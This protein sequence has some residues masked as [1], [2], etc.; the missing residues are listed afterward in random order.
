MSA[1]LVKT[2]TPGVYRRGSRYVVCFRDQYG[3]PRKRSAA[4]LAEARELKAA[5]VTDV[6]RGEY[7]P[8]ARLRF[9]AYARECGASYRGRTSRGIRPETLLD[10][11]ADLERHIIPLLGQLE[12][13]AIEP[14]DLKRVAASLADKGL[15]PA[16]IRCI[17]APLKLVLATAYEDGLIRANPA[18]GVRLVQGSQRRDP[19][20]RKA[21]SER[22]LL[23]FLDAV[24]AEWRLFFE[25]LAHSGLRIGEAV[26]L[27]WAD[28]DFGQR[29]LRVRRRRYRG[30]ID[31]L[32]CPRF[33]GH[34]VG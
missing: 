29:R 5:V 33:D 14:R 1:P 32:E 16:S 19:S 31:T 18:A 22:E 34:V 28:I 27:T 2:K 4:T 8:R 3:T 11:V 26:A 21:L 30:R 10:Y 9:A 12:L 20:K 25:L 23:R 17:L 7:R 6:R 15:M 24:P 13:T